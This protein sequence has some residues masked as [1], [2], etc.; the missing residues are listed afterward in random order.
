MKSVFPLNSLRGRCSRWCAGW[1]CAGVTLMLA[2]WGC[3]GSSTTVVSAPATPTPEPTPTPNLTPL[4]SPTTPPVVVFDLRGRVRVNGVLT[5]GVQVRAVGA[6]GAV[7][8]SEETVT[9]AGGVYSF[10]L[11]AGTYTVTATSGN[12]SATRTV[13]IPA[14]G[15]TVDNFDFNL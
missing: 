15:Q 6:A 9:G 5:A 1:T 3:G 7:T 13:T 12:R 8:A 4:P 11:G 14:G 10:F 2:A